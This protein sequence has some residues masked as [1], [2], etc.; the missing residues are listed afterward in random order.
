VKR[1]AV[2]VT[3]DGCERSGHFVG[4]TLE[5]AQAQQEAAGWLHGSAND[6]CPSCG[7][8]RVGFNV[9]RMLL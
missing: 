5:D 3:C 9:P 7:G 4:E 1:I 6:L 2:D 8:R